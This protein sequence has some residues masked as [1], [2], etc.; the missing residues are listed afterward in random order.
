MAEILNAPIVL[1]LNGNYQ[2][3]GFS[4]VSDAFKAMMGGVHGSMPYIALDI[5]HELNEDGTPNYNVTPVFY[6]TSFEDW[7]KLDIRPWD[8]S[9][10]GVRQRIRVPTVVICPNF[11]K[12]PNKDRR[13]TAKAIRERDNN[14]CQ[15]TG[16]RLTNRNFSLDHI[17]PRSRGGTNTWENLVACDKELNSKKGNQL[18]HEIGLKLAR[19]PVVP[20]SIPLCSLVTDIKH[21]DHSYF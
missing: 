13:P 4:T 5:Q 19:K 6:P 17:I 16:V 21:P 11:K 20:K 12:M 14:T 9:I 1:R 7:L 8:M 10:G 15:Y 3:L 2:R 18:N